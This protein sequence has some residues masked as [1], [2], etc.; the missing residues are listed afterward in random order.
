VEILRGDLGGFSHVL[1]AEKKAQPDVIYHLG[2]MLSTPSEA[3]PS[4]AM[5]RT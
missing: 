1:E 5:R 4:G 3:D 2:A